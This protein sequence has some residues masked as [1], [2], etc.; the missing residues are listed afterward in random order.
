M[1]EAHTSGGCSAR[2]GRRGLAYITTCTIVCS[3]CE[4]CTTSALNRR[5]CRFASGVS[6]VFDEAA[7]D[8]VSLLPSCCF[9]LS[10]RSATSRRPNRDMIWAS[11]YTQVPIA[12]TCLCCC[13]VLPVRSTLATTSGHDGRYKCLCV[14]L[15]SCGLLG[16]CLEILQ[17][18]LHIQFTLACFG[19]TLC[20]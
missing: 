11:D 9:V 20:S 3:T 1:G 8:S 14:L 4:P 17:M 13:C 18:L 2:K 12:I 7:W 6:G 15:F 5:P 16:K 10:H 19:K